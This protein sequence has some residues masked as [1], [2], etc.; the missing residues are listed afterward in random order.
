MTR[1]TEV[2]VDA[3]LAI[4]TIV[5]ED[6]SEIAHVLFQSWADA[7]VQLIAPA[8]YEVETAS[9]LRQKVIVHKS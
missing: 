8:F 4:K 7:K 9:I 6:D 1:T 2:C 3:G 5:E